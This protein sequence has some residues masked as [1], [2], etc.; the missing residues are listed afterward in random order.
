MRELKS[1]SVLSLFRILL[2]TPPTCISAQISSGIF[3]WN[4]FLD[5]LQEKFFLLE[6]NCML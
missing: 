3:V 6:C 4:I 2:I 5:Y 1:V